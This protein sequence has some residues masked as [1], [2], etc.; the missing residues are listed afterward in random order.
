MAV[1][2]RELSMVRLAIDAMGGDHAPAAIINGVLKAVNE[3]EDLSVILFGDQAK[4]DEALKGKQ[5]D[6]GRIQIAHAPQTIENEEKPTE[7]I[8]K[9]P[10]SSLVCGLKTTAEGKADAFVSAGST[11]AVLACATLIVRRIHGI[12]RAAL[13]PMLPCKTGGSVLLIDCGANV[14]CKPTY[15]PQF[16]LMGSVYMQHVIGVENPRV[17]LLNN[18]AEEGK[19]NALC[20]EAQ[21]LMKEGDFNFVGN[22][23]ARDLLSGQYDVVVSDGFAG[24]VALK[25]TEGAAMM[26]M[27]IIKQ[28]ILKSTRGKLGALMLKPALKAVQKRMDYSE[29]GGALLLGL[30]APVIKAHGSSDENAIYHAVI[31]AMNTVKGDIVGRI[32][33]ALDEKVGHLDA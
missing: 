21:P 7:A 27:S 6:A 19:G 12:Q 8:R 1:M 4:I 16:G 33:R 20:K 3:Y 10:D 29:Y 5:Y 31:Q 25:A 11:G 22:A 9:K 15:M 18:G 17:A 13:A 26:L 28:E 2:R 14:D 24:N 32:R 23:E 30:N